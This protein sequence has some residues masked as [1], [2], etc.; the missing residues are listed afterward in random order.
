MQLDAP[1]QPIEKLSSL[2]IS[3]VL[4]IYE[5]LREILLNI[6]VRIRD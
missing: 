3:D 1:K 5:L 4:V 6:L 2:G